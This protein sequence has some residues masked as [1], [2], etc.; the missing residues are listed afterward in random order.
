[1]YNG[2]VII[3]GGGGGGDT[4]APTAPSGLTATAVSS[5]QI[6]LSWS[7]STDNVGVTGYDI[8]R[9]GTLVG[10]ATSTSYSDFGLTASTN[11]SYTVKAKDGAGN[12]SG[13][14]NTASA[15]TQ[16]SGTSAVKLLVN[17]VTDS[18]NDGNLSIN[19]LDEDLSTRW[20]SSG[21][22]QWINYDLGTSTSVKY[23]KIAWYKGD[24]RKETFGIQIST[25]NVNFTTMFSGVSCGTTTALETYD[26]ADTTAR[27]VRIVGHGNN[28]NAWNSITETEIWG[29]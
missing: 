12:V 6:N 28:V 16:A 25:D 18:A 17:N 10:S 13:A 22:G 2:N 5:S 24:T 20:S 27:Y 21:D 9:G 1:M 8:Y 23:V 26:F 7:A 11:Y 14:S 3:T 29:N 4:Q 15:T 19:S